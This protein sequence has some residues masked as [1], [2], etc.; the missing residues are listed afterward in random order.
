MGKKSTELIIIPNGA[1]DFGILIAGSE[2]ITAFLRD[3]NYQPS[4]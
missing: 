1:E 4:S 3:G 2:V